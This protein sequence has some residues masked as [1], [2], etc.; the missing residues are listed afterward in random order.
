MNPG[1]GLE[2]P[3]RLAV[4]FDKE[5][6]A[7]G[8]YQQAVNAAR[9]VQQLPTEICDPLFVTNSCSSLA[10]LSD[11][12]IN[13]MYLPLSTWRK[14][15]L[16]LRSSVIRPK[17]FRVIQGIFGLNLLDRF[18]QTQNVDL[19]YFTSPSELALFTERFNY[20]F[21]VWDHAHRD[22]LEFPEVRQDRIFEC[23][24]AIYERALKKAVGVLVDAELSRENV[25]RRYGIDI[26]RVH[27]MPF[28]PAVGANLTDE[29]YASGYMDIKLK[30]NLAYDYVYYPAQL[31]AHK[32]HIYLLRGLYDLERLYGLKFGAI[33]SGGDK[34]NREYIESVSRQLGLFDRVVFAG[35]VPND[36]IPYLY[37]QAVALVMPTYFGPTNL[38]PLEA[39]KLGVPVLYS[40]LPGLR[41]QVGDA[42][43]LMD[44]K[45]SCSLAKH[46]YD[47]VSDIKLSVRLVEKGRQRAA[48]ISDET[49]LLI[50]TDIIDGFRQRRICW[51]GG[52]HALSEM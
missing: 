2:R 9:L 46:L 40:D 12:G 49:R 36:E 52:N 39:F 23:R 47:A 25:A 45:D 32:N 6:T 34:G 42:A 27:V 33:F 5:I 11:Y 17:L 4:F 10:A 3:V 18:L 51:A 14:A 16:R 26:A 1:L 44:L 22:E 31:W 37:R 29:E 15:L 28:S 24:E 21:T 50:L 30:Y 13:A 38:P 43:L 20:L 41:D 8:G 35:F 19:I 48:E 7:G